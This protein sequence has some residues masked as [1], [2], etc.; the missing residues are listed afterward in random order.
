MLH[1]WL[2][3]GLAAAEPAE[4][5]GEGVEVEVGPDELVRPAGVDGIVTLEDGS[6]ATVV[7]P[8][9]DDDLPTRRAGLRPRQRPREGPPRQRRL[10]P[11]GTAGAEGRDVPVGQGPEVLRVGRPVAV[12][13]P[14]LPAPATTRSCTRRPSASGASRPPLRRA[15]SSR[16]GSL[17]PAAAWSPRNTRA[18]TRGAVVTSPRGALA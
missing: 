5:Q 11:R 3:G 13:D 18:A 9:D 8:A 12:P 10:D 2:V 14:G 17:L 6:P 15:A 16:S 7:E 1:E 4:A